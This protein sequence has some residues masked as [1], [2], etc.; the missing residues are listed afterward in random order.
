ME[1]LVNEGRVRAELSGLRVVEAG[2]LSAVAVGCNSATSRISSFAVA[3]GIEVE[4][5]TFR[6]R[7]T[8]TPVAFGSAVSCCLMCLQVADRRPRHGHC[9]PTPKYLSALPTSYKPH[10]EQRR[11]DA[12]IR[13]STG[14]FVGYPCTP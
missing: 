12:R 5:E 14:V 6:L 11:S 8:L 2:T 9:A 13:D 7:L 1:K 10:Q 3:F 4:T